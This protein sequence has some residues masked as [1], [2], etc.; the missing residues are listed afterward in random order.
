MLLDLR[1]IELPESKCWLIL[2]YGILLRGVNYKLFLYELFGLVPYSIN[3][4]P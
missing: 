1:T 2:K 4:L 3:L